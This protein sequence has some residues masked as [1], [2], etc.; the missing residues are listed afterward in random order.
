MAEPKNEAQ[1]RI[2]ED[3]EQMTIIKADGTEV[4]IGGEQEEEKEDK[5]VMHVRLKRHYGHRGREGGGSKPSHMGTSNKPDDP[6]Q[7]KDAMHPGDVGFIKQQ[8]SREPDL[9][10]YFQRW[11][12]R[13]SVPRDL[14]D[15]E[16]VTQFEALR[17]IGAFDTDGDVYFRTRAGAEAWE[18]YG[19]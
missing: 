15:E 8:I 12:S 9:E 5:V 7:I 19:S 17:G 1:K 11:G 18:V 10:Q 6:D 13:K 2:V 3:V 14:L 4:V 16:E